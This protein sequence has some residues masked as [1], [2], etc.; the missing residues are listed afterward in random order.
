MYDFF[1]EPI[2]YQNGTNEDPTPQYINQLNVRILID[3]HSVLVSNVVSFQENLKIRAEIASDTNGE[4]EVAY[5]AIKNFEDALQVYLGGKPLEIKGTPLKEMEHISRSDIKNL[6]NAKIYTI[7][8]LAKA[9]LYRI[10]A[11]GFGMQELQ[12]KAKAF[13]KMHNLDNDAVNKV[14]AENIEL[15]LKMDDLEAKIAI[16]IN[17]NSKKDKLNAKNEQLIDLNLGVA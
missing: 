15:K 11:A 5:L 17:Q 4:K 2:F 14:T 10:Q 12:N 9:Q 16:L 6:N 13:L 3:T 8:D 7:E 1:E